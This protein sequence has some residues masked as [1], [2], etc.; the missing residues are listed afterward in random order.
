MEQNYVALQG[1]TFVVELQSMRGSTG[2]GWC[3][4]TL[5]EEVILIG[6]D[7]TPA[8]PGIAPL[9]QK[10]YFGVVSAQQINIEIK[11]ILAA[12][13]KLGE[14]ADTYTAKVRIVPSNSGNFAAYGENVNTPFFNANTPFFHANT[15]FF[16]VNTPFFHD[17]SA[18]TVHAYG[19]PCGAQDTAAFKYGYPCGA[20][21]TAALKYGYPCGV[22]DTAT[23]KY[24][25]PC[26]AQDT[27]TLKYGYP[28]GVQDT[29]AVKYGY[30]CGVQDT[31]ALKYGYPC[32]AQ[33]TAA[34]KYGYP[35]GV[36]EATK[37]ARPYGFPN[38]ELK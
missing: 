10:F 14:A 5:P 24:G 23:L 4:S 19:Y 16:N 31:A 36:E 18:N 12:P 3:L 9:I 13:W 27:A 8:A 38:V 28:C 35:C 26:G 37:D 29:A 20:Q 22:Q 17:A 6:T 34:L 2:Y 21:D 11:F 1:K 7:E 15:P 32:G 25:Y 30:P 33:D